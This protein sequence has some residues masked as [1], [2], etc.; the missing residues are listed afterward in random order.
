MRSCPEAGVVVGKEEEAG[1]E[2]DSTST[3]ETQSSCAKAACRAGGRRARMY[4]TER[5]DSA[6]SPWAARCAARDVRSRAPL[7]R[8]SNGTGALAGEASTA[9]TSVDSA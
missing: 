7:M 1:E 6:E 9:L 8:K 2:A 3:A 4:S 5:S